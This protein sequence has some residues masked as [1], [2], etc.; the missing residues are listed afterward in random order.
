[1]KLGDIWLE[2]ICWLSIV[3]RHGLVGP[4]RMSCP[5]DP[6]LSKKDLRQPRIL[7][8][9]SLLKPPR[10]TRGVLLTFRWPS[11]WQA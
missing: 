3:E 9:A 8:L 6:T 11:V 1:M 5:A 10:G 2:W 4:A 7:Y